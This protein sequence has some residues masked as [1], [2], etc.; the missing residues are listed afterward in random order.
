MSL[1][2][3]SSIEASFD[4]YL[5]SHEIEEA[6]QCHQRGLWFFPRYND[7]STPC[8]FLDNHDDVIINTYKLYISSCHKEDMPKINLHRKIMSLVVELSIHLLQERIKW[9]KLDSSFPSSSMILDWCSSYFLT[10]HPCDSSCQSFDFPI[11]WSLIG[12]IFVTLI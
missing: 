6:P 1:V 4:G 8:S 7:C 5:G 11:Y 3:K 9:N 12:V 10:S 2:N